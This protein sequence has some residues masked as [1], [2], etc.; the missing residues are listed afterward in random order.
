MAAEAKSMEV[1]EDGNTFFEFRLGSYISQ[2]EG[3]TKHSRLL[4]IA[5]NSPSHRKEAYELLIKSL[6]DGLNTQLYTETFNILKNSPDNEELLSN[7]T[8]DESWVQSTRA[9]VVQK[10]DS[11]EYALSDAKIKLVKESIRSS[12]MEIGHF[13]Y[14][15]GNLNEAMKWFG[16]VREYC[17]TPRH[18][19]DMTLGIFSVSIDSNKYFSLNNDH[20]K[21]S[22]CGT[23][24][25]LLSKLRAAS[26]LTSLQESDYKFAAYKF[27]NICIEIGR[28]FNT[29]I[30]CEDIALYGSL[31]CLATFD[32]SELRKNIFE[33]KYFLNN[34]LTLVPPI[35]D[36][37]HEFFSGHYGKCLR[38]LH[39]LKPRL[40]LDIHL[41]GH[42]HNLIDMI[43]DRCILQY[44]I[45]YN[46]IDLTRMA[47]AMDMDL[48]Q[49]EAL[50]VKLIS[51]DRLSA[52]IDSAS[53]MLH[54]H[55]VDV[56]AATMKSIAKLTQDHSN[57]LRR[58][59]LQLS[60]LQHRFVVDPKED[61]YGYKHN[62]FFKGRMG[63]SSYAGGAMDVESGSQAQDNGDGWDDMEDGPDP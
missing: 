33:K 3:Y 54:K 42:A 63:L 21:A 57:L 1:V 7:F 60:L 38:S 19:C 40:A 27:I 48:A 13:Q 14:Y 16:R 2:Y 18:F 50:L 34:F 36:M 23:D 24:I 55:R 45:P 29:I 28:S 43:T 11:L 5:N 53:K 10:Q 44:C 41:H 56:K 58:N 49:L 46:V 62:P 22:D 12:M 59:I 30:T 52:K 61:I 47:S 4:F 17:S 9:I 35:R 39:A 6:M 8:Y 25:V 20:I 32:R 37:V 26:A 15:V 31:L 51:A